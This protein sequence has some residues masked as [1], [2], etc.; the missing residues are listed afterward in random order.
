ML[1]QKTQYA[2]RAVYEL[3]R[4]YGEGPV[5]ISDIARQQAIPQRFLEVILHQLKP[6]FVD[7][8]R[9]QEGG[10]FLVRNPAELAVGEL[11]RFVQGPVGPVECT[12]TEGAA[13]NCPLHGDCAF[14]SLWHE[15]QKATDDI[16]DQTTFMDL[17]NR[18]NAKRHIPVYS[19]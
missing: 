14:I 15:V 16:Y 6:V 4:H 11:L 8:K 10:Y 1:S 2:L 3:A 13:E 12:V 5:K 18:E 7:S 19:I 17:I 9:G